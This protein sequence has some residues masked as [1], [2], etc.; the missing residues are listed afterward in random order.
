MSAEATRELRIDFGDLSDR[1][2]RSA[3]ES[4]T[5]EDLRIRVEALLKAKVLDPLH[6]DW[7]QYELPAERTSTLVTG[8]RIDAL[9]S[10]VVVEYER[11]GV[12]AK[13]AGYQHAVDQARNGIVAHSREDEGKY[14]KYLG[15]VTDG[16]RIGFVK[17][18][19]RKRAFEWPKEPFEVDAA[20]V[21]RLI[22]AIHGLSRKALT[23]EQLLREFGPSSPISRRVVGTFA[24]RLGGLTKRR[25]AALFRD[26]RR[27]FSQVC[28]YDARK[29]AGLS[30]EY[31]PEG[32]VDPERVLFAV[33]TYFALLMKLVVAELVSLTWGGTGSFLVALEDAR[34]RGSS[35][36]REELIDLENGGLF[37]RLGILNFIQGDY[38]SWYTSEWDQDLADSVSALTRTL[39]NYDPTTASLEPDSTRDLFKQLY[40]HL[41]PQQ[42]RHDLGEFYT[43]DWLAELLL[44][45]T[46]IAPGSPSFSIDSTSNS[47][48]ALIPRILDPACGSGT[49]LVL[50]IARARAWLD[51]RDVDPRVALRSIR[52]NI[53][54][55]DLNPL[56]VLASRANYLIALGELLRSRGA[57]Q[58]EIPVYFADSVLAERRATL[59]G[60]QL[61]VLRTE[62]GEFSLPSEAVREGKL[63][64][65]ISLM[66]Q[67]LDRKYTA[68]EAMARIRA[69]TGLKTASLNVLSGLFKQLKTLEKKDEDG[70]WLRI[71]RNS[72][73]PL[74]IDKFDYVVGNPP[75]VHWIFLPERY[76]QAT[77][78][79]WN[80]YRLA[81]AARTGAGVAMGKKA[82]DLSSLFTLVSIDRYLKDG[83]ALGFLVP[84]SLFK[85]AAAENFRLRLGRYKIVSADDLVELSPF[86]G[87]QNRT[88]M[89]VVRKESGTSWPIPYTVWQRTDGLPGFDEDLAAAQSH[90]QPNALVARPVEEPGSPWLTA[91]AATFSALSKLLGSSPYQAHKGVVFSVIGA[92][93][94]NPK[95]VDRDSVLVENSPGSRAKIRVPNLE[96]W[97]ERSLVFPL[98]RSEDIERWRAH[99][100]SIA[101]IVPH[102]PGDGRVIGQSQLKVEYPK[103]FH[104]FQTFERV[105]QSV[106]AQ[107]YGPA[108]KAR[109]Q[110]IWWL[111]NVTSDF[112]APAKVV[113]KYIA[114]DFTAA[115]VFSEPG[116]PVVPYEKLMF[117]KCN[118]NDE[119]FY[120]TAILNSGEVRSFVRAYAIE[121]QLSTHILD[122]LRIPQFEPHSREHLALVKAAAA[123]ASEKVTPREAQELEQSVDEAA[124][125]VFGLSYEEREALL[126]AKGSGNPDEAD[127]SVESPDPTETG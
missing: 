101:A 82:V 2:R 12:L 44:D 125:I 108:F 114:Q 36:L 87:A 28:A 75:W 86:E 5:E 35:K 122:R 47:T 65:V 83:G 90:M 89:V 92:F 51:E 109:Q 15:V 121:T 124:A 97:V 10:H 110:P 80:H 70:I 57:D 88:A 94:V 85:S 113:W 48:E 58:I 22:E 56:A 24:S 117:V 103:A 7:A 13:K 27:V 71:L 6:L 39:Y 99:S 31:L 93:W 14:R 26:W 78:E 59:E 25:T 104:W 33:H 116:T 46:G 107:P 54:G 42:I 76:R 29:L 16:F 68:R 40:Q 84:Q 41:V 127:N 37:S 119:A 72:F 64:E 55:F 63:T 8:V 23:A 30:K 69:E 73:A 111:F 17:F 4:V 96:A 100:P 20:T 67:G 98:M 66:E 52:D 118:S 61:H 95:T 102:D 43:P 53:V 112:F 50:C 120:L 38:F 62:V 45:K 21:S 91:K 126:S 1:I 74:L 81:S 106:K 18:N 19:P 60:T 77:E 11:P 123:L 49:F 105:I 79:V 32:G 115:P 9:H 3:E 34:V